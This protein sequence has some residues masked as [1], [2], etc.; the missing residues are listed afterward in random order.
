[1]FN[2]F[3]I[4]VKAILLWLIRVLYH[5]IFNSLWKQC[6]VFNYFSVP[7]HIHVTIKMSCVCRSS[8][9][10]RCKDNIPTFGFPVRY[11][12]EKQIQETL[13]NHILLQQV[14]YTGADNS[15]YLSLNINCS[16]F[17]FHLFVQSA[18]QMFF[19]IHVVCL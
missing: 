4:F 13:P 19:S 10:R 12:Q 1:M 18:L 6:Y 2:T 15:S 17:H 9:S 11:G 7:Y 5:V 8:A 16:S 14:Q 3:W